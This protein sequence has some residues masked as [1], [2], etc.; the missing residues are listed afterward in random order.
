MPSPGGCALLEAELVAAVGDE[1]AGL[2]EAALVEQEVHALARGETSGL[3][4]LRDALGAAALE[5]LPPA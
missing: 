2:V 3:V 1:D 5:C 4:D